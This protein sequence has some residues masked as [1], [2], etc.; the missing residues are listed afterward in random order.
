MVE[1]HRVDTEDDYILTVFRLPSK[2]Q[3]P[4][5]VFMMHGES[6]FDILYNT[7]GLIVT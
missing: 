5:I 6:N 7:S 4:K 3:N 1:V 2:V